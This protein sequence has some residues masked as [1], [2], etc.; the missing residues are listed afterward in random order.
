MDGVII[1]DK[2]SDYTSFDVVAVMRGLC[3]QRKIGHTGTLDPMATGVLIILLGQATKAQDLLPDSDKEYVANFELGV[4]TDTLD[5]TGE[6]IEEIAEVNVTKEDI[7]EVLKKYK[8]DI[9]Q[10]PPMYS[11]VKKDGKRL[12]DLARKGI[13]V[14]REAREI[15]INDIELLSY[16]EKF[17][18]GIIRVS[19]SKGTYIRS[20]IDDIGNELKV[21]GVLTKL[22]RT[23]ACGYDISDAITLEDFKKLCEKGEGN[24][25]LQTIESLFTNYKKVSISAN[26]T[27]RFMNGG[28]LDITRTALKNSYKDSEIYRVNSDKGIFL[29]L[30]IIDSEKEELKIYKLFNIINNQ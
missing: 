18:K 23:K 27:K 22:K 25:R 30:G 26:Q 3:K 11:A 19:C 17:N 16:D 24:T 13:E 5:I 14:E 7:E 12:Y 20:L 21:G 9:L 6:I 8:G 29:G 4:R 15:K 10:V 28:A 1:I 2:P